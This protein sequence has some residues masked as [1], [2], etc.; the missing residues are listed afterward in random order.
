MYQ[1]RSTLY[2]LATV[3]RRSGSRNVQAKQALAAVVEVLA[4]PLFAGDRTQI[5]RAGLLRGAGPGGLC[6]HQSAHQGEHP[7][8]GEQAGRR[9]DGPM[10]TWRPLY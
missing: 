7:G 6:S 9:P 2:L 1:P 3:A 10:C 8:S 4:E 5:W